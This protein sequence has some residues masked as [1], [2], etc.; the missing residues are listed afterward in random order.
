VDNAEDGIAHVKTGRVQ[1]FFAYP[2]DP[3]TQA[4]DVY[5]VNDG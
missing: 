3:T 1:A 5:G 2:A 4:I